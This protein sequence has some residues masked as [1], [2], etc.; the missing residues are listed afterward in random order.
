MPP[1]SAAVR[2]PFWPTEM[3]QSHAGKAQRQH[4]P[5]ALADDRAHR[6]DIGGQRDREPHRPGD[7]IRQRRQRGRREQEGRRVVPAVIA[8][9]IVADDGD[10]DLAMERP[11]IG[12]G[13][14]AVEHQPARRPHRDEVVVD[15]PAEAVDQPCALESAAREK[16]RIGERQR[17]SDQ[18][19][20]WRS[21]VLR[22]RGKRGIEGGHECI[23][24]RCAGIRRTMPRWCFGTFKPLAN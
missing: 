14:M 10:L 6:H 13:G 23:L 22:R 16:Q 9:K 20:G 21:R 12:S 1:I 19:E 18:L 15:D 3:F 4:D 5:E 11:V 24:S 8:R 7:E 17:K 2:K